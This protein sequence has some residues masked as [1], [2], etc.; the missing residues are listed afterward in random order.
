MDVNALPSTTISADACHTLNR[1]ASTSEPA[2]QVVEQLLSAGN[3]PVNCATGGLP[4]SDNLLPSGVA[5]CL[6]DCLCRCHAQ[7]PATPTA[8]LHVDIPLIPVKP[9]FGGESLLPITPPL[10]GETV[11]PTTP[12]HIDLPSIPTI[13]GSTTPTDVPPIS[14][15]PQLP[16]IVADEPDLPQV[17]GK[18]VLPD[19]ELGL[20]EHDAQAKVVIN[21]KPAES[22][23]DEENLT[24]DKDHCDKAA[25]GNPVSGESEDTGLTKVDILP[26]VDALSLLDSA[27]ESTL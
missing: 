13:P 16:G 6:A 5:K 14:V 15:N 24:G 1:S 7:S 21:G 10:G 17:N 20:G 9:P 22:L 18:P 4:P 25:S 27:I 11:I 26:E 23:A 8:S 12:P 19:I 3:S 2:V